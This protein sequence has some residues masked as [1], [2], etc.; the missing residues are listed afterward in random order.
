LFALNP[1]PTLLEVSTWTDCLVLFQQGQVDAISTDDVVLAGLE[2]QDHLN[3]EVVGENMS[4]EPYGV[5]VNK[6]NSDLV[7][8]VNGV[9]E[10]MRDDGTW[11]RLYDAH[12]RSFGPSPGPP[13]AKYRD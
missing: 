12:L 8:F 11:E 1:R 6:D 10:Q 3:V 2:A 7:R 4:V 9:L 13:T 5:G